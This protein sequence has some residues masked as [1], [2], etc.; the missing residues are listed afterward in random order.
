MNNEELNVS[1]KGYKSNKDKAKYF[2]FYFEQFK[3][4]SN[5]SIISIVSH[6]NSSDISG[7]SWIGSWMHI[8]EN[9]N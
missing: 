5:V 2:L 3:T 6:L 4:T 8:I 1:L 7:F 9:L